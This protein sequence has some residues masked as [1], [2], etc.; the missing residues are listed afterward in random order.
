MRARKTLIALVSCLLLL[1]MASPSQARGGRKPPPPP[2]A[3]PK[4]VILMIGD[5]MGPQQVSL[6][7]L[8]DRDG[9]ALDQMD[10]SPGAVTT[11]NYYG[12]VTDSAAAAT[13]MA[14]GFKTYNGAISVDI[15]NQPLTTAWERAKAA[16]KST[17]IMSS[18]FII[19]A[20]PGVWT[21]HTAD[22]YDYTGVATAE[23]R[24]GVN[25]LMGA[26]E[27]YFLPNGAYG[28]GGVDLVAEMKGN[29]YEYVRKESEMLAATAPEDKLVGF[30]GGAGTM[31]YSLNRPIK[32]GL[33]EPTLAQMTGKAIE[34][35]KRDADGFF[36]VVEGGGIDWL[37]HKNDAA[38]TAADVSAFDDAVKVAWDFAQADGN[39]LV[40]ATGDHET[41]GLKL[42]KNLANVNVDVLRG[43]GATTDVIWNEIQGGT[44]VTSAMQQ[45]AGFT[46][47]RTQKALIASCDSELG[48]SD[49]INNAANVGWGWGPCEGG[50][51]T[52]TKVPIYAFGPGS[53]TFDSTSLD[54]TEIGKYL[55]TVLSK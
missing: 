14:T 53:T 2:S 4:N 17:G 41:G 45:Y 25:V 27:H 12:E 13:A 6:G 44:S 48:V 9:L 49:A 40:I 39:T 26:G 28:T 19:D 32:E 16:G 21:A 42:P 33:T 38:G 43:V 55:L 46:P 34:I 20:T 30:F 52:A 10:K 50:H 47:D 8:V 3:G 7:R 31:T 22:R 36:L 1:V 5:G 15:N 23:A 37:A 29:G 51:H 35:L 11:N 54:N 24:S 18:V